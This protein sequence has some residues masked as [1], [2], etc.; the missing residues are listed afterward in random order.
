MENRNLGNSGL[1]VPV[2]SLGT[3]TFAG[4]TELFRKWGQTDVPEASRMIDI[5][6][7]HGLNFFDTANVYSTGGAETVLGK[8]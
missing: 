6:L 7:E 8:A 3:A 5:S 4:S 2:L 1:K